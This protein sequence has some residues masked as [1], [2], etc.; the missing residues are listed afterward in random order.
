MLW[1]DWGRR[2]SIGHGL[3]LEEQCEDENG[4]STYLPF[5]PPGDVALI[6]QFTIP[7]H[8]IFQPLQ[9]PTNLPLN[10]VLSLEDVRL[11]IVEGLSYT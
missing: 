7:T 10:F 9:P 5:N 4:V 8:W 3:R 11:A 6:G 2:K 1:I